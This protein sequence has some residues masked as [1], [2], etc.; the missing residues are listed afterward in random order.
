MH[1]FQGVTALARLGLAIA[2][3]Y[4]TKTNNATLYRKLI[5]LLYVIPRFYY[6]TLLGTVSIGLAATTAKTI[7]SNNDEQITSLIN[8]QVLLG[9]KSHYRH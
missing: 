9:L 4:V 2:L 1:L 8:N 5:H 7:V 6:V 3:M